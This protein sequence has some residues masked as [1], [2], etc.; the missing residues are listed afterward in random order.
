[1][2]APSN[3]TAKLASLSLLLLSFTGCGVLVGNVKPFDQK[4]EAYGVVDLSKNS[5]DW[6][7]LDPKSIGNNPIGEDSGTTSTEV[8]DVAYQSKSTASIIS[9]DSACGAGSANQE[10]SLKSL[11]DT[12]LLG[13]SNVTLRDE[14]PLRVEDT[15]A[16]QTTIQ[17]MIGG[18]SVKLRTVVLKRQRCVY[19]LVYVARPDNF[20]LHESDFSHFVASLRLK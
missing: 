2:N 9:L 19:D 16:L 13:T 17:G 7:R 6:T 15:P 3:P 20:S 4:S 18:E 11:T 12:L 14:R 5:P 1:M 10:R 8:A